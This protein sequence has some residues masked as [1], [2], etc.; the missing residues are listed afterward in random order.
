MTGEPAA[1][2]LV[3]ALD[4]F[5]NPLNDI[6]QAFVHPPPMMVEGKPVS[7]IQAVLAAAFTVGFFVSHSLTEALRT[8]EQRLDMNRHTNAQRQELQRIQQREAKKKQQLTHTTW[9]IYARLHYNVTQ[10][11]VGSDRAGEAAKDYQ[12][13]IVIWDDEA[14]VMEFTQ[15]EQAL[16][17]CQG[18]ARTLLGYYATL[19]P[20]DPQPPFTLGIHAFDPNTPLDTGLREVGRVVGFGGRNELVISET[21]KTLMDAQQLS[22]KYTAFSMGLYILGEGK[23]EEIYRIVLP[24]QG[25]LKS[26]LKKSFP[27][28]IKK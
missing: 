5:F 9:R 20:A 22:A 23:Q 6:L 27:K 28:D 19:R 18:I 8:L 4:P 11:A 13:R 2:P 24:S 10:C 25:W 21:V 26:R 3:Q 1:L 7:T 12:A 16:Q 17:A 14:M 15:L